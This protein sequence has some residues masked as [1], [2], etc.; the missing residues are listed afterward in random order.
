MTF[1][2]D[3]QILRAI[4]IIQV[5][6][7]HLNIKFFENG[8][9]GVDIFF[10]ISGFLMASLYKD[11]SYKYFYIKRINRLLPPYYFTLLITLILAFLYIQYSEFMQTIKQIWFS[12]GFISNIGFWYENSYFNKDSF[13]PL[14]HLWSLS[15]EFQFYIAVPILA[16][17]LRKNILLIYFLFITSILFCFIATQISPKTSFFIIFFRIWEFLIG[18][19]IA[20]ISVF[21][22]LHKKKSILLQLISFLLFFIISGLSYFYSTFSFININ[23]TDFITGHPGITAL[24]T[25]LLTAS[26]LI[27]G[28]PSIIQN[29]ILGNILAKIGDYSY[30]LYLLHYPI[31]IFFLYEPFMGSSTTFESNL[32][33]LII[34]FAI[35]LLTII[36]QKIIFSEKVKK[37]YNL[38]NYFFATIFIII[39]SAASIFLKEAS[40][41]PKELKIQKVLTYKSE[42][43]CGKISRI[44]NPWSKLCILNKSDK[45]EYEEKVILIGDSH[46]DSIKTAFSEVGTTLNKEVW[47]VVKNDPLYGNPKSLKA[48]Q[49]IEEIN[50]NNI[51][52][53]IIHFSDISAFDMSELE[54]LLNLTHRKNIRTSFI[55]PV[56][57]PTESVPKALYKKYKFNYN[58]KFIDLE[59]YKIKNNQTFKIIESFK[60][61]TFNFYEVAHI[62]CNLK[63][64]IN[65]EDGTPLYYDSHHLSL[66]GAELLKPIFFEILK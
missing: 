30:S 27:L 35:I 64:I 56:P 58:I 66:A 18:Y 9:L 55:M 26:L 25:C 16:F 49:L 31:I 33:M 29:S 17:M 36:F 12:L 41:N 51:S 50:K 21:K 52:H 63:C 3:I 34:L 32:K 20:S 28:L 48:A 10:V 54:K 39:F 23:A 59:F 53:V 44:L 61:N 42:F 7:F 14:L 24:F 8:Y 2:K 11:S 46:A 22:N 4:A 1:R 13:R 47:F 62:F 65:L 15:I 60:S 57:I 19:L 43:R 37:F 45:Q 38:K 5:L 40:L 6:F